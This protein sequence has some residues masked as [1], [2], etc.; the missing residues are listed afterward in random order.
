MEN[1][2]PWHAKG[3][4]EELEKALRNYQNESFWRRN[5]KIS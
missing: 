4:S 1:S 3:P 5:S 2:P